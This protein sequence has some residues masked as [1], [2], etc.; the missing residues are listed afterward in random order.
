MDVKRSLSG[1]C[2]GK[3]LDEEK[4]LFLYGFCFAVWYL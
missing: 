1:I 3:E 2:L 4:I